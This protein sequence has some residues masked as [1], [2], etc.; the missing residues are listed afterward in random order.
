MTPLIGPYFAKVGFKNPTLK[1][2]LVFSRNGW[3]LKV[4]FIRDLLRDPCYFELS[5]ISDDLQVNL[6]FS[7]ETDPLELFVRNFCKMSVIN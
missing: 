5:L 1:N 4:G 3:K 6:K 7:G 2:P